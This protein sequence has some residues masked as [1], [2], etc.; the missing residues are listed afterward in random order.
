MILANIRG[1]IGESIVVEGLQQLQEQFDNLG[2][3]F[4]KKSLTKAAKA[5]SA[6]PLQRAKQNIKNSNKPTSGAMKRGLK[7]VM[8]TP[9]KRDK[10]VYRLW[11]DKK[12]A[13]IYL[14]KKIVNVGIYGGKRDHGFYPISAEYG[15]KGK[16]G[17]VA[18]KE[19][20]KSAIE[21][22]QTESMQKIVDVLNEEITR[23]VR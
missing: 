22:T 4:P 18:G 8:E 9:H 14:G 5:G 12:L 3:K 16:R 1:A 21:A 19:W 15:Y 10:S 17:K 23:I 6:A 13:E 7:R 2:Q 20:I 11:F